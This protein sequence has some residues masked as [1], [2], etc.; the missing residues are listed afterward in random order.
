M[1]AGAHLI[2]YADRLAGSLRGLHELLDG[3][4]AGVFTGVHVLP[5]FTPFDGATRL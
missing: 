1:R 3:P 5:F 4:L 2:A